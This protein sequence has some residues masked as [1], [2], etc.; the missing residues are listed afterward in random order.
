[1]W[2]QFIRVTCGYDLSGLRVDTIYP[3]Y[4]WIR[5]IQITSAAGGGTQAANCAAPERTSPSSCLGHVNF[6]Q[7]GGLQKSDSVD[8]QHVATKFTCQVL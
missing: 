6:G 2:I 7:L 3:G 4:V 5:F 8:N 1:M